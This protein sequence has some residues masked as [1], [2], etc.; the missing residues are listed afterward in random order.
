MHEYIELMYHYEEYSEDNNIS[1]E[2]GVLAQLRHFDQIRDEF[3]HE[4]KERNKES[5]AELIDKFKLIELLEIKE[6]LRIAFEEKISS[7]HSI[8]EIN[9]N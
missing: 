1:S 3:N 9:V 2:K 4:A 7:L 5:I 8:S 6:P